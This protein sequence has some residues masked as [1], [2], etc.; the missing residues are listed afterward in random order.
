[1]C[2]SASCLRS[3]PCPTYVLMLEINCSKVSLLTS[4]DLRPS[5]WHTHQSWQTAGP[6]ISQTFFR[7]GASIAPQYPLNPCLTYHLFMR[8]PAPPFPPVPAQFGRILIK[9]KDKSPISLPETNVT[10]LLQWSGQPGYRLRDCHQAPQVSPVC[11]QPVTTR[12]HP[13]TFDIHDI[14]WTVYI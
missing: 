11:S 4:V 13:P 6:A 7:L 8:H 9:S 1:M 14:D 5:V 10:F 2:A 12:V 3:H